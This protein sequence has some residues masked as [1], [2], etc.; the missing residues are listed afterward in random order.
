MAQIV[1]YG[2]GHLATALVGGF[3]RAGVGS[4]AIYNRTLARAQS[5]AAHFDSCHAIE[6]EKDI[7]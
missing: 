3:R 6:N 4:I 7:F 5:L 2:A 1:V